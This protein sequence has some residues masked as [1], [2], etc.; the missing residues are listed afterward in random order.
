MIADPI[1]GLD[2]LRNA[3]AAGHGDVRALS[4]HDMPYDPEFACH[5][6]HTINELLAF[7]D[8]EAEQELAAKHIEGNLETLKREIG[9]TDEE[10]FRVPA[11]FRRLAWSCTL[12]PGWDSEFPS[13]TLAVEDGKSKAQSPKAKSQVY[14]LVKKNTSNVKLAQPFQVFSASGKKNIL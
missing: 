12:P 2:L 1:A 7:E 14:S 6:K 9:L 4:R 11:T 10:V 8:P 13:D 3:S 5:P